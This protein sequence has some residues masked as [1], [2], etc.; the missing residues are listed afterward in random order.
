MTIS[1]YDII[2]DLVA[3]DHRTV[4]VFQT[5]GIDFDCNGNRNILE[6][7]ENRGIEPAI[8]IEDLEQALLQGHTPAL[9]G[10]TRTVKVSG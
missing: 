8:L 6:A 1:M 9:H 3:R 10:K 5:F 4:A 2:D 7:C